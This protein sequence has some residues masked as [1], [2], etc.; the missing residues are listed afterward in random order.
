MLANC[1][2][3]KKIYRAASQK[4]KPSKIQLVEMV[5]TRGAEGMPA[6]IIFLIFF[7]VSWMKWAAKPFRCPLAGAG[8]GSK[9]RTPVR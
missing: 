9:Q 1:K 6:A 5:P 7:L 2:R 4:K 8:S 3:S